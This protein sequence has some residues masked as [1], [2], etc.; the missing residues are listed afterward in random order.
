MSE[1]PIEQLADE[2]QIREV[3]NFNKEAAKELLQNWCINV[4]ENMSLAR[5][6]MDLSDFL[7]DDSRYKVS[8]K[9]VVIV[10]ASPDLTDADI[11]R[12]DTNVTDVIVTNKNFKRFMDLGIQPS[13]VC[14]IDAHPISRLQFDFLE[15]LPREPKGAPGPL[16]EDIKFLISTTVYPATLWAIMPHTESVYMFN[17]HTYFGG[18]A[19]LSQTWAWMNDREEL[20][21][22]GSVGGLAL[23]LA[24]MI[25]YDR[26]GLLGFGLCEK[27]NPEWTIEE[28]KK[29]DHIY[30]PDTNEY[31]SIPQHFKAYLA[32]M[33]EVVKDSGWEIINLS[34]SPVLR[35]S[36]L[37]GQSNI[38]DFMNG[39]YK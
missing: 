36:P 19:R 30:Y 33:M 5:Q 22:G 24:N 27:G 6:S 9:N 28:A 20:E 26:V 23:V 15:E 34:D 14:L 39:C 17:P 25:G 16:P 3:E 2:I 4:S 11:L 29:R 31:V 10:G 32:F 12:I 8:K 1:C 37:L 21:H 35:H 7:Q 38:N 13:W 18:Q